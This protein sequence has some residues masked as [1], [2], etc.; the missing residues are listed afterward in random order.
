MKA[1]CLQK[2]NLTVFSFTNDV[3]L[4]NNS[5]IKKMFHVPGVLAWVDVHNMRQP[6]VPASAEVQSA[7]LCLEH[8]SKM[9]FMC[10]IYR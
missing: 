1:S 2:Y 9:C 4:N 7:V 5:F 3:K 8:A 10:D 6:R